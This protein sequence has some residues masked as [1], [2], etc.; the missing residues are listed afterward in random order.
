[1]IFGHGNIP[2]WQVANQLRDKPSG[3]Y[4]NLPERD[5]SFKGDRGSWIRRE[6]NGDITIKRAE[7]GTISSRYSD[8]IIAFCEQHGADGLWESLHS[9]G[10]KT[11]TP[12][13]T[14]RD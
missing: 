11:F 14:K 12:V 2:S 7:R 6:K 4:I 8:A 13:D 1:M 9:G 10:K 3:D 5:M